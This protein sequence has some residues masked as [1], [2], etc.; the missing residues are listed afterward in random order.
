MSHKTTKKEYQAMEKLLKK[1]DQI[2]KKIEDLAV[3]T[4]QSVRIEGH[5]I[6]YVE[7]SQQF[8][9]DFGEVQYGERDENGNEI[10]TVPTLKEVMDGESDY[11][12]YSIGRKIGK[13]AQYWVKSTC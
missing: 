11:G 9:D 2:V 10:V 6:L 3:S 1:H 13:T 7:G 12:E 5:D 4:C 8:E